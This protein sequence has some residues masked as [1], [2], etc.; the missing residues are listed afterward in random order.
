MLGRKA[1]PGTLREPGTGE[2]PVA[3]RGLP[4]ARAR[5]A[6]PRARKAKRGRE[7]KD[8]ETVALSS[9]SSNRPS[10]SGLP[11]LR[12]TAR[13]GFRPNRAPCSLQGESYCLRRRRAGSSRKNFSLFA[14]TRDPPRVLA[15]VV[16]CPVEPP[17]ARV[18]GE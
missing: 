1:V 2:T 13:S 4:T 12:R 8:S 18:D 14:D 16:R 9:T 6:H 7:K 15:A 11:P 10:A 17:V 5:S 3:H